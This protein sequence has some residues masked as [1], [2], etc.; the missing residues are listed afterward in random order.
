MKPLLRRSATLLLVSSVWLA[1]PGGPVQ[2]QAIYRIVGPD[3]RVTFSDT[4]PAAGTR[5]SV[6]QPEARSAT[7]AASISGLPYELR[8]TVSRYPVTLYT[9]DSCASCD[10]GRTLLLG[11][12]IPFVERTVTTPQDGEVLRRL[13]G[14]TSLPFLTIGAQRLRGFSDTEWGQFLSAAGYPAQSQLPPSYR[15]PAPMALVS[16]QPAPQLLPAP[17]PS[18]PSPVPPASNPAGISF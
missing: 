1:L 4:P 17:Q 2:A 6:L 15:Q 18:K 3:G 5:A 8:Q 12:G 13:S 16:S 11:R 10:A 7:E 14:D 9:T